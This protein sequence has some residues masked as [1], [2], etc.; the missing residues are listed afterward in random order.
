M[1]YSEWK[2][3][4]LSEVAIK[5]TKGTTPT[6]VGERFVDMGVN[7]IKAEAL[8]FDGTIDKSKFV[9]I[10]PKTIPAIVNKISSSSSGVRLSFS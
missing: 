9:C 7:Y 6:T 10:T 5:I 3:V 8:T 4:R 2:Q 1:S